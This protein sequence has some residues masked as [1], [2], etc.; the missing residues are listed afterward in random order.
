MPHPVGRRALCWRNAVPCRTRVAAESTALLHSPWR[1]RGC[2]CALSDAW[3]TSSTGH[4]CW[5][6]GCRLLWSALVIAHSIPGLLEYQHSGVVANT[7]ICHHRC[8]HVDMFTCKHCWSGAL[9]AAIHE[10]GPGRGLPQGSPVLIEAA[11]YLACRSRR[12]GLSPL[13]PVSPR[14][15][16]RARVSA[17]EVLSILVPAVRAAGRHQ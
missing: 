3:M 4:R 2:L 10:E 13:A 5:M 7:A 11:P 9:P 12:A 8:L 6:G 14:H 16:R 15:P 17:L 1:C